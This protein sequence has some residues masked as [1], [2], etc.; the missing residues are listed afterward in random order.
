MLER[1]DLHRLF[2]RHYVPSTPADTIDGTGSE[3]EIMDG[4]AKAM[5][6]VAGTVLVNCPPN[7]ERDIAIRRLYDAL[8]YADLSLLLG[9]Y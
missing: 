2:A 7:A 1:D 9:H 4:F 6:K 8:V 3:V 5:Y